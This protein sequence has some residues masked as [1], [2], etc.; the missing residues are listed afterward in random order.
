[1][2]YGI[3]RNKVKAAAENC[4]GWE[5]SNGV[6][7][8][9]RVSA[10]C[11]RLQPRSKIKRKSELGSQMIRK[12]TQHIKTWDQ[13]QRPAPGLMTHLEVDP[14][15]RDQWQERQGRAHRSAWLRC[16]HR[17]FRWLLVACLRGSSLPMAC[18]N[19]LLTTGDTEDSVCALYL[20]T[21]GC[22]RPVVPRREWLAVVVERAEAR[23][24]GDSQSSCQHS[25]FLGGPGVLHLILV[26]KKNGIWA[27]KCVLLPVIMWLCQSFRNQNP[28]Q[29]VLRMT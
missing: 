17:I 19:R 11:T 8:P 23:V 12:Y 9:V 28:I 4:L 26:T 7:T 22:A 6:E 16:A 25:C 24:C 18:W 29:E 14:G 15:T 13:E 27:I 21:V 10:G 20:A 2:C 1:M 3:H 5:E